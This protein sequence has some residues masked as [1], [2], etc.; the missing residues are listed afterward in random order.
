VRHRTVTVAVRCAISFLFLA[1]PTVA[2]SW[3]LAH[4]TVRCPL[5]TIGASH[6]SP[7]DCAVD[8][9]RSRPLAHRTVRC[10]IG[11]SGEFYPYAADSLPE[12]DEF[13]AD[14]SPDSPVN[15]SRMPPSSPESGLVTETGRAHRTL[16][17]APPDSPVHSDRA[18]VGC[19]QPT[20]FQLLFSCF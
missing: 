19:T 4:R 2:D 16:S 10:T 15:Y 11:Q 14:D 17:G 6:A 20:I 9:W 12:S 13:A 18:G 8:R 3:Q 1:H 7:A 5:P